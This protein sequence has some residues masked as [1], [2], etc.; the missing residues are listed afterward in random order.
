MKRECLLA[1]CRGHIVICSFKGWQLGVFHGVSV[2]HLQSCLDEFRYCLNR[3]G[4]RLDG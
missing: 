1:T 4:E 2:A 3:R